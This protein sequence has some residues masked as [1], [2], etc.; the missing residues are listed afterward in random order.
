MREMTGRRRSRRRW[1]GPATIGRNWRRL[2]RTRLR[3]Q[4]K[5]MAFLIA[6]MPDHDLRSLHADFLLQNV[7]LAYRARKQFP[8]GVRIPEDIFLNDVLPYANV[9]EVRDPWRKQLFE[10]W[11]RW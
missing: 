7:D 10:L 5:G 8:W 2:S 3:E 1:R 9:D 6:N 4:R 11:R